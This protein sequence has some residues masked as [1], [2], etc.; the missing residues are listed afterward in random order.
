[1]VDSLHQAEDSVTI[2][3]RLSI[4]SLAGLSL[5]GCAK[6]SASSTATSPS[7]SPTVV[8]SGGGGVATTQTP[9][10]AGGTATPSTP[11]TDLS[12][13]AAVA[14]VTTNLTTAAAGVGAITVSAPAASLVA[15][16]LTLTSTGLASVWTIPSIWVSSL[17]GGANISMATFLADVMSPA[18]VDPKKSSL[19]GPLARLNEFSTTLC[20]LDYF[21]PGKAATGIAADGS[22]S[23]TL[24]YA[25]AGMLA[26]CPGAA[27]AGGGTQAT[28]YQVSTPSDPS[29][30]TKEYEF[31]VKSVSENVLFFRLDPD[32][33]IAM[34]YTTNLGAEGGGDGLSRSLI[35]YDPTT[36][37]TRYEFIYRGN[38]SDNS[39]ILYRVLVDSANKLAYAL[40]H[41]GD[42]GLSQYQQFTLAGSAKSNSPK[43]AVGFIGRTNQGVQDDTEYD[44]CIGP[45]S[46]VLTD[47]SLACSLT[48]T[49]SSLASGGVATLFARTTLAEY[50]PTDT[51]T[52]TFTSGTDIF[53]AAPP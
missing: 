22:G 13:A 9:S 38:G 14:A 42:S 32:G 40:I 10:S 1:M 45:L 19:R 5:L 2:V 4:I 47:D 31:G 21:L 25:D 36:K 50:E 8:S 43:I 7:P 33:T 44:G 48:G 27:T 12:A 24:N 35:G 49:P 23:F 15:P 6:K 51:T 11:L 16:P 52:L 26:K 46:T 41:T 20:T 53:T 39:Y 30:Y 34:S 37:I 28:L 29:V 17:V 18:P 3:N